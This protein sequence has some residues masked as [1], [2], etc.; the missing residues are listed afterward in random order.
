[1]SSICVFKVNCK[2]WG[3]GSEVILLYDFYLINLGVLEFEKFDKL[4]VV[5][6]DEMLCC[7]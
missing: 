3:F 4:W 6:V 1:M 5:F 7:D 2:K